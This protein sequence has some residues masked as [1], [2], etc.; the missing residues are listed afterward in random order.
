MAKVNAEGNAIID[1][2]ASCPFSDN[3]PNEETHGLRLFRDAP[4]RNAS[5]GHF[6]LTFAGYSS[7]NSFRANG[8]FGGLMSWFLA[9]A[10]GKGMVDATTISEQV[11]VLLGHPT[12]RLVT[13]A[14]YR[15]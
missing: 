7:Q 15:R 14:R 6:R 11:A 3:A 8:S 9:E 10:I 13:V 12:R 5:L 4:H 2:I 1:N